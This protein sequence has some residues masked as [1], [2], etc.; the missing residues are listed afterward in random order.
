[1]LHPQA[2]ACELTPNHNVQRKNPEVLGVLPELR[3]HVAKYPPVELFSSSSIGLETFA[4]SSDLLMCL[5]SARDWPLRVN[6]SIFTKLNAVLT[7]TRSPE[8][9]DALEAIAVLT[10]DCC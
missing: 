5:R 2:V 3:T 9:D 6:I 10:S 1:M 7:G 8:L 4:R